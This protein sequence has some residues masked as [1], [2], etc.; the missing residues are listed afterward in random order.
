[1]SDLDPAIVE[2][3][4]GGDEHS[5]RV[6]VETYSRAIYHIAFRYTASRDAAYDLSQEIFLHVY[7]TLGKY[8]SERPFEPWFFR[9]ATNFAINWI[10]KKRLPEVSLD[11]FEADITPAV[12]ETPPGEPLE[13]EE[14]AEKIRAAVATLEEKYRVVVTLRYLEEMS[15]EEVGEILDLPAGTV[16]NRLYR[17]REILKRRLEK[18]VRAENPDNPDNPDGEKKPHKG[19]TSPPPVR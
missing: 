3:A 2:R 10:R 16:K 5:F 13:R 14:E 9:V 6:V 8:D 11:A 1:V 15:L 7:N 12:D 17:A 4:R 18:A 19:E